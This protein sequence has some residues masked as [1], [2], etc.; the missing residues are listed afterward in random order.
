MRSVRGEAT[1]FH[2]LSFIPCLCPAS[3]LF[4]S[5]F[6]FLSSLICR[7]FAKDLL[8]SSYTLSLFLPR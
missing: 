5:Y 6:L 1:R 8:V 7:S 2:Y 3:C 4:F